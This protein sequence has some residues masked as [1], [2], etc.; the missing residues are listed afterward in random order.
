MDV[1]R[2]GIQ[3]AFERFDSGMSR[4]H[5][6][7]GVCRPD[8]QRGTAPVGSGNRGTDQRKSLSPVLCRQHETLRREQRKQARQDEL[9]RIP[10][11]GKF[12]QGKRRFG[13]ARIMA[14][15][16]ETARTVIGMNLLIMNLEKLWKGGFLFSFY[17]SVWKWIIRE[18]R[19]QERIGREVPDLG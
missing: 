1:G 16:P 5:R 18:R 17:L 12:G 19:E 4:H 15:L 7:N 13:L 9:D 6:P 10:I 3:T 2:A 11:E 14:K 8:H